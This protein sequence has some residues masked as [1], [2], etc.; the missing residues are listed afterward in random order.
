MTE[1]IVFTRNALNEYPVQPTNA[2][3]S[4]ASDAQTAIDQALQVVTSGADRVFMLATADAIEFAMEHT[5]VA[6][7]VSELPPP[8]EPAPVAAFT[9][10]PAQPTRNNPITFDASGS[11]DA[12][13]YVWDFG[14]GGTD[15][16]QTTDYA[17]PGKG[18]YSVTLTVDGPGGSDS[19]VQQVQ[20]N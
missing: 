13:D 6:T 12:T 20:V 3:L 16:G 9:Y 14:D 2:V 7:P 11:T 4:V 10:T 5:H 15:T 19:A 18:N 1:Y 17:Y 8:D